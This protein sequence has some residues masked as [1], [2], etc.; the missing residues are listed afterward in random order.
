MP[1]KLPVTWLCVVVDPVAYRL[2]AGPREV[3]D[4]QLAHVHVAA[5]AEDQAARTGGRQRA[6]ELDLRT[7]WIRIAAEGLLRRSVDVDRAAHLRQL[8]ERLDHEPAVR[9]RAR[10]AEVDRARLLDAAELLRLEQRLPQRAAPFVSGVRHQEVPDHRRALDHGVVLRHEVGPVRGHGRL[11]GET[12][13]G[14]PVRSLRRGDYVEAALVREEGSRADD[15]RRIDRTGQLLRFLQRAGEGAAVRQGERQGHI[16]RVLPVVVRD[17]GGKLPLLRRLGPQWP[18]VRHRV[19]RE[20]R[21]VDDLERHDELVVRRVRIVRRD[22]PGGHVVQA[23]LVEC[24][25]DEEIRVPV[26]RRNRAAHRLRAGAHVGRIDLLGDAG[27]VDLDD[28]SRCVRGLPEV[29]RDVEVTAERSPP[30]GAVHGHEAERR[31]LDVQLDPEVAR[32]LLRE[33]RNGE[34]QGEQQ[35]LCRTSHCAITPLLSSEV[36]RMKSSKKMRRL[37][38]WVALICRPR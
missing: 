17:R 35:V 14:E 3:A 25:R 20:R 2:D 7:G 19:E 37:R 32:R 30:R 4:G 9:R 21:R 28:R 38:V 33:E 16:A 15:R 18:E 10:D 31:N 22:H 13:A 29:R 26:S 6:V 12:A 36:L 11:D 24:G 34:E 23:G 1:R 5:V 8:G 27:D